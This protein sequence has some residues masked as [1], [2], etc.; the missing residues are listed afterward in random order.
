LEEVM[1]TAWPDSCPIVGA[2]AP[3]AQE[4][5]F[6]KLIRATGFNEKHFVPVDIGSTDNRRILD[7]LREAVEGI[8]KLKE[9]TRATT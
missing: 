5:L 3:N 4:Q 2:C 9:T 1:K 8:L 7:H 6:K